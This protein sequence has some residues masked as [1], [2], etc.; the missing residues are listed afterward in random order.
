MSAERN[1]NA[2]RFPV[3]LTSETRVARFARVLCLRR[4][5][6]AKNKLLSSCRRSI[7]LNLHPDTNHERAIHLFR[8]DDER[9]MQICHWPRLQSLSWCLSVYLLFLDNYHMIWI[10]IWISFTWFLWRIHTSGV[11]DIMKTKISSISGG[12]SMSSDEFCVFHT[13]IVLRKIV[14]INL[15][16]MKTYDDFH[17]K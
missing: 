3:T 6:D 12:K 13:K 5:A 11:I 10:R 17:S 8:K 4:H 14:N 1:Y 16:K 9:L 15:I 7:V 2:M